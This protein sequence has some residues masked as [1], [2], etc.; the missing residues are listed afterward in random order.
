MIWQ[1]AARS[2]TGTASE[3]FD[4][5]FSMGTLLLVLG[6]FLALALVSSLGILARMRDRR[7]DV[8][9]SAAA[10]HQPPGERPAS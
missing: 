7:S 6:M 4:G 2:A 9:R 10:T 1:Q 8:Q 3:L 5:G